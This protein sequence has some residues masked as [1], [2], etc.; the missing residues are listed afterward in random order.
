VVDTEPKLAELPDGQTIAYA[1]FGDPDGMPTFYFHGFPGSRLEAALADETAC[2]RHVRI[3][4]PD[5]PGY[6]Y[7]SFDP[8]RTIYDWPDTVGFLA[9]HLG[10]DG[11]AVVGVSGGGPYALACAA[12]MPDR[13][14]NAAVVCG[15]APVSPATNLQGMRWPHRLGLF[16][17]RFGP[18]FTWPVFGLGRLFVV[19]DGERMVQ[20]IQGHA[21]EPDHEFLQDEHTRRVLALSFEQAMRQASRG[22]AW[23]AFL[24]AR[25]WNFDL[26]SID[27]PVYAWYGLEDLIVPPAMGRYLERTLPNCAMH[28]C[29]GEGHFSLVFRH[30]GEIFDTAQGG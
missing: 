16:A 3:I 2:S 9:D 13:L 4:A 18:C 29:P 15:L 22:P 1:E 28:F 20:F 10:L 17:A 12:G 27:M 11:F 14:T 7:S 19:P 8:V 24:Y 26:T 5:R 25:P 21:A 23:D 30:L 6:G